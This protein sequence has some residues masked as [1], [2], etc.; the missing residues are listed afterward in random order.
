[1]INIT[2]SLIAFDCT[3]DERQV[4]SVPTKVI[5]TDSW[6]VYGDI[7]TVPKCIFSNKGRMMDLNIFGTIKGLI[8]NQIEIVGDDIRAVHA[9]I[10]AACLHMIEAYVITVPQT[11][12][13]VGEVNVF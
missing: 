11:L 5:T 13:C 3:V 6:V 8:T 9:E 12:T 2:Q 10:V 1:M 7:F 4:F